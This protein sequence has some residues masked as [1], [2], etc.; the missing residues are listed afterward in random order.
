MQSPVWEGGGIK[1]T[2]E[3]KLEERVKRAEGIS[4]RRRP[5]V[6]DISIK[7]A[8]GSLLPCHAGTVRLSTDSTFCVAGA[9][10]HQTSSY[11]HC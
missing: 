11:L 7:R 6:Q 8:V 2:V 3:D 5:G 9:H 4:M 10:H 1:R